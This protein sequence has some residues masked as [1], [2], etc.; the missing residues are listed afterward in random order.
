[1]PQPTVRAGHPNLKGVP[2]PPAYVHLREVPNGQ[3]VLNPLAPGAQELIVGLVDEVLASTPA[4]RHGR[5]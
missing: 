1:M 3:D 2:P 4:L 5:T